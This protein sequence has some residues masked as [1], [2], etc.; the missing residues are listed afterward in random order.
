MSNYPVL[1]NWWWLYINKDDVK[2]VRSKAKE[3]LSHNDNKDEINQLIDEID[4]ALLYLEGKI[5]NGEFYK[6]GREQWLRRIN[7]EM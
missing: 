4:E 5:N 2:W 6:I 1:A 3:A 7:E